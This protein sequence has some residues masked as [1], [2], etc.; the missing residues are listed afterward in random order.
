MPG[1][2]EVS[3]LDIAIRGKLVKAVNVNTYTYLSVH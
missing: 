1:G 3:G 2:A